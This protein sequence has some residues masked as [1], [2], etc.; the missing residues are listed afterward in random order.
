MDVVE[1]LLDRV[2]FGDRCDDA[3]LTAALGT[4]LNID[5]K[6]RLS[7]SAQESGARGR[8]VSIEGLAALLCLRFALCHKASN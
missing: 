4:Q 6:T 7:R 8:S 1:D 2:W 5:L 3:Q